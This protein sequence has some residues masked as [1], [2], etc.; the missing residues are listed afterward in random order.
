MV[1]VVVAV[2]QQVERY[3]LVV[4]LPSRAA[5]VSASV[6]S[7]ELVP[8]L[9]VLALALAGTG[10]MAPV[11]VLALVAASVESCLL[12]VVPGTEFALVLVPVPVVESGSS[13]ERMFVCFVAI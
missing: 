4:P 3:S 10:P 2:V 11:V 13:V 12:V 9:V 7:V 8:V 6:E 5:Q 1:P